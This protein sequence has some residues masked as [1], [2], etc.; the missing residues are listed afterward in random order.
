MEPLKPELLNLHDQNAETCESSKEMNST[1]R[2]YSAVFCM[3]LLAFSY[4]CTCGWPS[5]ALI[6]LTDPDNTP[7]VTGPLTVAEVG[8]IASSFAIGAFVANLFFGWVIQLTLFL[9]VCE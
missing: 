8:W 2:Q 7:L 3:N 5:A 6:Q 4:G 9:D 1:S